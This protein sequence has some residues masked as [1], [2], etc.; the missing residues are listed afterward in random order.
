MDF[1]VNQLTF[2]TL[3]DKIVIATTNLEEDDIIEKNAKTL[4]IDCFRG[5]SDDVLDRY[6]QCAKKF[7]INTIVRITSDCPLIDPQIVDDVIRKYQ[8]EDYDYVTNTLSRSYPI[9]T[10]V[11]IAH[12]RFGKTV[13]SGGL[14]DRPGARGAPTVDGGLEAPG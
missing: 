7:Q 4:G 3:I 12:V 10:D 9:G 13:R 6:Y 2:S 14:R 11:E 8:H 1:V 5:S